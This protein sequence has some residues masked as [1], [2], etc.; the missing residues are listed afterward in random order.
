MNIFDEFCRRILFPP[1]SGAWEGI[2]VVLEDTSAVQTEDPPVSINSHTLLQS[3]DKT[4]VYKND[5]L[6]LRFCCIDT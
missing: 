2:G 1:S 5:R 4:V 3:Q 6:H